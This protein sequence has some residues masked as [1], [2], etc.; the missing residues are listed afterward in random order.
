MVSIPSATGFDSTLALLHNPYGFISDTC[1]DLGSDLFATRILLKQ[2]ICMTG[3]AAAEV[4]YTE[5]RLVRADSMPGRIRK[6]LLGEGGV[7]GLDGDAHLHRKQMFMSLM[8]SERIAALQGMSLHMLDTYVRDWEA[9]DEVIL[10]DEVREMLTRA[11]CAWAGVLLPDAEVKKR[12]A[13]LTALFQDAGAVGPKHW[14]ARRSRQKLERWTSRM[15]L[16]VRDDTLQ[17]QKQSA[18]HVI[19]TWR[20][21]DGELLPPKVAAVEL[22]NVLRPTVAVSVFIVHAVHALHWYPEWSQRLK[23]D[24]ALLEPFVQEVRRLYPFFPAVAARVKTAFEWNGY[25]FPT[26]CRV[27]LD[28]Y[29]TNTDPRSWDAPRDFRPERFQSRIED[30]YDFIPQGGG[31]HHLNH[32]CPGEWIAISQMKAF[33]EYFVGSIDYDVPDQDLEIDTKELPPLPKTQMILCNPLA[34]T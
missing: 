18:L 10:Y 9:A 26:G 28:L 25:R 33:C 4:F 20:D 22:L 12:T 23:S 30:P 21:P 1:R 13:Q 16:E 11:V 17:P 34:A 2:T 7:Q 15:I 24:A 8:S 32:R 31:D 27:L 3:A 14:R 6:T 5:D 29:G 19:A